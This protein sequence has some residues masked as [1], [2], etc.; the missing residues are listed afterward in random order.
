MQFSGE[1]IVIKSGNI[2]PYF[3]ANLCVHQNLHLVPSYIDHQPW[4]ANNNQSSSDSKLDSG[5]F[6]EVGRTGK[7]TG[8]S[9]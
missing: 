6:S 8:K 3:K 4:V 7:Q 9:L 2:L 1:I 5:I